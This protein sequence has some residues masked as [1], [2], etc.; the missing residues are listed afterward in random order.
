VLD[1]CEHLIDA[2]AA[3]TAELLRGCGEL[4]VVATSRE[5]LRVAGESVWALGP[6]ALPEAGTVALEVIAATDAVAL[7][8]ERAAE[9]KVGFALGVDNS[10][11]VTAICAHLEGIPLAIELAA[12]RVRALPLSQIVERLEH[13]LDVLSKGARGAGDR[14][15]S[16]RAAITWSHDLLS[17]NER[18]LFRR[19]SAFAGGF[20]L[21]A[22]ED[23][24]VDDVLEVGEVVEAIDGLVDKSL[25]TL[26]GERAGEG[27]YRLL[28]TIRIYAAEQL[29]AAGEGPLLTERHAAF[30]AR[31]AHDLA[32]E[33]AA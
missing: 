28:E 13:S 10:A 32:K 33:G 30:Y 26:D 20:T 1:N 17:D 31:L 3:L 12:A 27:R 16:L 6:L 24:C 21:D 7:F 2:T 4:R 29:Q 23:V 8:C 9:A 14:H 15:A 25:I 5:P 22:A 11:T 19:T 18:T